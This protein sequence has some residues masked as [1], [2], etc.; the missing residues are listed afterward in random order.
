MR[1]LNIS[2]RKKDYVAHRLR[3]KNAKSVVNSQPP[4]RVASRPQRE[5]TFTEM[6]NSVRTAIQRSSNTRTFTNAPVS[7]APSATGTTLTTASTTS[8][9]RLAKSRIK[10]MKNDALS[11]GGCEKSTMLLY[12]CNSCG[13]TGCCCTCGDAGDGRH[14]VESRVDRHEKFKRK[15][16]SDKGSGDYNRNSCTNGSIYKG[17]GGFN[18]NNGCTAHTEE[19]QL[20]N[21]VEVV[22]PSSAEK[23]AAYQHARLS[24]PLRSFW[25]RITRKEWNNDTRVPQKPHRVAAEMN[26]SHRRRCTQPL[27]TTDAFHSNGSPSL[28][29]TTNA[30]QDAVIHC[31]IPQHV[32]KRYQD[33]TVS[34]DEPMLRRLLRPRVFFDLEVKGL[35]PLGR[36]VIQLFTEACPEVVLEFV[37]MCTAENS[38]RMSFTRLFPPLWLEGELALTDN[39]TLTAPNIEHDTNVLDHGCGAGVLSFPSRYVRGSKRRF[40]SFSISFKP[41]QVLNGKRIAFGRVR[42]GF[43]ILDTVQDYGTNSGKPQRDIIVTSCGMCK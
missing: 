29:R 41:L 31:G 27:T 37:R 21:D 19:T 39:K 4:S 35:R 11:I 13:S 3:V 7:M 6:L 8:P 40:L 28:K 18:G 30:T 32:I 14:T 24:M 10:L 42:R 2:E 9:R 38:E 1:S 12:D 25:H 22:Q 5:M 17:G 36:I 16:G 26:K 43:W 15:M 20:A 33:L 34:N 23:R